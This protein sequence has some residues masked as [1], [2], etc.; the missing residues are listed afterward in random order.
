M[1]IFPRS[2]SRNTT[3][4]LDEQPMTDIAGHERVARRRS[5]LPALRYLLCLTFTL[6]SIASADKT[7]LPSGRP[8][9][10]VFDLVDPLGTKKGEL[11]INTL[12]DYST[13]TGQFQWSPEIEYSFAKGHAIE[14]E[15]PVDNATL[16]EYKVSLQGTLGELFQRRMIHGWQIIGRRKNDE[17][18]FGAEALYLNDYKFSESW[19]MMNM[20]GARRTRFNED[21]EFVGLVNNSVFYRFHYFAIGIEL[22]SEIR[23]TYRYR[24]TPQIQ[25]G[26]SKKAFIQLGGGPS[27]LNEDQKTEWLITSRLVYDF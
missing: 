4:E 13:R 5:K 2:S 21:G 9:P 18:E 19:S 22:N 14:L 16:S 6:T 24:L 26:F 8:E 20:F 10:M 23:T 3:H 17:K 7:G 25:Y 1:G 11:E 27:H 15:L 12:L